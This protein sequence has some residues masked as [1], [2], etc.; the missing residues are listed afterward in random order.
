MVSAMTVSGALGGLLG[1]MMVQGAAFGYM[2]VLFESGIAFEGIL[3]A[4]VARARPLA[5]P[6]VALAYGYLRQGAQLM[7]VRTDVPAEVIGVVTA[8]I[9]LL[10]ASSFTLPGRR[11]L[12]RVVGIR[13]EPARRPVAAEEAGK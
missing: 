2:T 9:I 4:I 1:S 5:V 12:A 3:V 10:V 8:L 11:F 7:N 13:T 6:F